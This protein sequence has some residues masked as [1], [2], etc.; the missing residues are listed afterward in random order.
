MLSLPHALA[1]A[2]RRH[3]ERD[4]PA[5]CCGVLLGRRFTRAGSGVVREVVE[6]HACANT[7]AG[8]SG[9][10]SYAIAPEELI[11]AQRAARE[12]GLDIVGF[13][14]SHPEH[15][16]QPSPSDIREAYWPDCV[17]VIVSVAERTAREMNAFL[18]AG[19][20]ETRFVPEPI[21]FEPNAD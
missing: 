16:A 12:R 3:A 5:E 6:V 10:Q 20:G 17:Y 18:A 2:M 21:A 7:L 4:Y 9:Q 19:E 11:A 14:H 1:H 15:P 13:Y 8:V